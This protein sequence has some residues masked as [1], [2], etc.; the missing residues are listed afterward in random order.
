MLILSK[1]SLLGYLRK[2][3]NKSIW[4]NNKRESWIFKNCLT[5][6]FYTSKNPFQN[7][8]T[9]YLKTFSLLLFS[10]Y[11]ITM[12]SN[13]DENHP[14]ISILVLFLVQ[15]KT[16]TLCVLDHSRKWRGGDG[17]PIMK[18]RS[19]FTQQQNTTRFFFRRYFEL[20]RS[21]CSFVNAFIAKK[22]WQH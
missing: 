14:P 8:I 17:W 2:N 15:K 3:V 18:T 1:F 11:K 10:K 6:Y 20:R 12:S 13:F 5:S 21:L 7:K 4:Q 9:S 19:R 16:T 22:T